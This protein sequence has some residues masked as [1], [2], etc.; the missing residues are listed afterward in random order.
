M[1]IDGTIRSPL[2]TDYDRWRRVL[3]QTPTGMTFQRMDD[4]FASYGLKIDVNAKRLAVSK[5]ADKSWSATFTFDRPSPERLVL[6]GEMDGHKIHM[7]LALYDRSRFL[8]V[9]RGFHWIQEYP[10]NR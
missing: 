3:F 1:A 10:F 7:Q 9:T 4:T 5:A 2:V 8:L 6:D